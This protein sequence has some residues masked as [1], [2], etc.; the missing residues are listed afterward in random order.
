[1]RAFIFSLDAFVAFTLALMA[2]YSLIFFSSVPSAYYYLIT[3]AHYLSRDSLLSLSMTECIVSNPYGGSCKSPGASLLDN[4]VAEN[5]PDWAAR[6]KELVTGALGHMIPS[7]FGYS[8]EISGDEGKSWDMVYDSG[9][10][11]SEQ[12]TARTGNRKLSVSSQI[13]TFG[14][15][16]MVSKLKT[17][18][19]YYMSCR[20]NGIME[21]GNPGSSSAAAS[22]TENFALITCG[23]Y[24]IANNDGTKTN[25]PYGN[26]YPGD[27]MGGKDLVPAADV[28]LVKLTVYI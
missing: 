3:Q 8:L 24:G 27:I 5:N 19:Y 18:P 6:Q 11:A 4:I 23:E 10:H 25:K 13:I 15:S 1:M 16:G 12:H 17:S 26:V 9:A 22:G 20:G 28:E 2:I 21:G 7:Q 14:Y